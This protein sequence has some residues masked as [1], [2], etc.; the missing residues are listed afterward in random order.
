[1]II[2][3]DPFSTAFTIDSEP[4]SSHLISDG[5]EFAP[6][7]ASEQEAKVPEETSCCEG[8]GACLISWKPRKASVA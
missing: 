1:M 6:S 3:V 7:E 8:E 2:M 4:S 5:Q